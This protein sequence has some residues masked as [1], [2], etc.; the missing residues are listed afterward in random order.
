MLLKRPESWIYE[1]FYS[2]SVPRTVKAFCLG[3]H[4]VF[5]PLHNFSSD[6][7]CLF[8]AAG[9]K[10]SQGE[11]LKSWRL[12]HATRRPETSADTKESE[13]VHV[14]MTWSSSFVVMADQLINW[15]AGRQC[16]L[17]QCYSFIPTCCASPFFLAPSL[18][19]QSFLVLRC[20]KLSL[21]AVHAWHSVIQRSIV[22]AF[23][24][25]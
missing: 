22:L 10:G 20:F 13:H 17:A 3:V 25:F 21:L 16:Q 8:A 1:N 24:F 19:I 15:D 6:H 4:L 23:L 18:V 7:F 5:L 14:W 11:G 9:A 2:N 12:F